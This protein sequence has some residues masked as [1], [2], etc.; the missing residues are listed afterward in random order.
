M[1]LYIIYIFFNII[2]M[3]YLIRTGTGRT[4][5]KWGGGKSTKAKYLRRTGTSRNSI[6]WI[7]ISSNGTYNVLERTSTGRNNIRWYNTTFT[8]TVNISDYFKG[9]DYLI[10]S[11][12]KNHDMTNNYQYNQPQTS[13]NGLY[14]GNVYRSYKSSGLGLDQLTIVHADNKTTEESDIEFGTKFTKFQFTG[15]DD[16]GNNKIYTN[17]LNE[18]RNYNGTRTLIQFN[19]AREYEGGS[20]ANRGCSPNSHTWAYFI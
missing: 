11:R 1:Y 17:T 7:D 9:M 6:S 4:N 3:S 10:Y 8:F 14:F 16:G 2:Y 15:T 13:G 20:L 5:I 19:E 12:G 18:I